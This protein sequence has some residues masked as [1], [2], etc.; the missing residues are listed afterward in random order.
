MV[1][2]T[3]YLPY[4]QKRKS[5]DLNGEDTNGQNEVKKEEDDV[6]QVKKKFHQCHC[7]IYNKKINIF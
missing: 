7:S 1:Y 2:V 3:V 5:E 4:S 6:E